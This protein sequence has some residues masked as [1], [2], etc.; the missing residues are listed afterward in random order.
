MVNATYTANKNGF[1]A[2]IPVQVFP[3]PLYPVLQA[4][5][6]LPTVLVQVALE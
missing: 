3:S 6:K 2:E 4:Q 1:D 5:V